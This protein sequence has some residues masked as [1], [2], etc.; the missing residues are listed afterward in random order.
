MPYSSQKISHLETIHAYAAHQAHIFGQGIGIAVLDTGVY[1]HPD[2]CLGEGRIAAFRDF[3]SG[4]PY[5]YDDADHGTHVCGILV[6]EGRDSLGRYLGIAPASRIIM[7]KILDHRGNG[8]IPSALAAFQW[9]LQI[10]NQYHIRIVN[11]SVGMP[12]DSPTDEFSPFMTAVNELWDAGLIVVAAAGNNGPKQKTITAPGISRK[13]ITVGSCEEPLSFPDRA[14]PG[15][16]FSR[17]YK[18]QRSNLYSGRGPTV[19]CIK[20][21]DITAPGNDIYS[22]HNQRREY[23]SKS[24]TSMSTPMVS[25]A[26]ALLLSVSPS[27]SNKEVKLRLLTT[28]RDLHLPWQQQGAGMLDIQKLLGL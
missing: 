8:K 18:S 21:P 12:V 16:H 10:K 14:W 28:A 5:P 17:S 23:I 6:S 7:A 2:L 13:I 9:I 26:L 27:L 4:R 25:G 11:I 22:C 3:V 15:S 19:N 1:P 24:G 20:K